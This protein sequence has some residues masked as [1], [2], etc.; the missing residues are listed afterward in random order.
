MVSMRMLGS[1]TVVVSGHEESTGGDPLSPTPAPEI[2]AQTCRR[3]RARMYAREAAS[4]SA[5]ATG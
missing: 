3:M 4:R 5:R 1:V 2:R